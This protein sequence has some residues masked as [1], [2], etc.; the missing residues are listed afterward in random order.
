[1]HTPGLEDNKTMFI[2]DVKGTDA[3]MKK[4]I[5]ANKYMQE[6]N[7]L[8]HLSISIKDCNQYIFE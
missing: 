2:E 6:Q 5:K 8:N 7:G 1:M 3:Y 4:N